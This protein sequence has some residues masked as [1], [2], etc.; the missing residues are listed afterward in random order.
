MPRTGLGGI[1]LGTVCCLVATL[2]QAAGIRFIDVPAD[3][4]G[5][6]LAGV[7]WTP[8]ATRP[9]P[10]ETAALPGVVNCPIDGKGLPLI[11]VSHG[12]RGSFL[13]HSDTATALAD[14]GFVVAAINHP[15]DTAKDAGRTDAFSVL[16][17]RP[18][19]MRRLTDFML[20]VWKEAPVLDPQRIGLFGFSR[21]A[22]T[23][24]VVIG[25]NPDFGALAGL[26][27]KTGA[28]TPK[29]VAVREGRAPTEAPVHDP[30][31]KA[32]IIA[33]PPLIEGLFTRERLAEVTIPMLLWRSA[34]GGDGV[35]P[36]AIDELVPAL[37]VRPDYRIAPNSSHFS[38]VRPCPPQLAE[39]A[40]VL[41]T[42]P[43]GFDR[44]AFHAEFNA[45]AV[46][47]F[48]TQL[49]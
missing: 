46:T 48:R 8:C 1:V 9:V 30:R 41:C 12:R 32:A 10:S 47:F 33:D 6:A 14:A 5:P 25:G 29:C 24:L 42:D 19:D 26:C 40:P 11:V 49:K 43:P 18:Q 16:I 15:G 20:G 23:G 7:V 21:G 27:E 39:A 38:F 35:V 44:R 13:A 34:L 45:A 3:V 2:A 31:I 36:E 22:Y 28:S 17:E 4:S 37:S